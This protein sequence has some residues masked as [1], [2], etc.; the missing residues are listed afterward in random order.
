MQQVKTKKKYLLR[1]MS[2]QQSKVCIIQPKVDFNYSENTIFYTAFEGHCWYTMKFFL[3]RIFIA[4][5]LW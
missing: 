4:E 5:L 2:W 1:K 3:W